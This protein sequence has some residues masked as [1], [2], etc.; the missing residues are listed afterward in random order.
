MSDEPL[1]A[2]PIARIGELWRE[3]GWVSAAAGVQLFASIMRVHQILLNRGDTIVRPF[4]LTWSRF[5]VLMLLIFSEDETLALGKMRE[6]LQVQPGAVT[7]AI[8]RLEADGLVKRMPD[9]TDGR[10]TLA[11]LTAR[12]R[13][14]ALK[15]A[16]ELERTVFR[17]LELPG[18]DVA[19]L[20]DLLQKFR[21]SAGDFVP[22]ATPDTTP[23][24][25]T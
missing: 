7:N 10:T 12:G 22:V 8:N 6:Q 15:V 14:L 17:D 1:P 16:D 21:A 18:R 23:P 2:D 5:E 3:H 24:R 25:A 20:F 13:K 19:V 11:V 9:P 4:G